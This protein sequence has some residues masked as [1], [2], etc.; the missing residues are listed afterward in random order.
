MYEMRAVK[1]RWDNLVRALAKVGLIR[2]ILL[3][4]LRVT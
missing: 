2:T 3:D 4:V 1:C